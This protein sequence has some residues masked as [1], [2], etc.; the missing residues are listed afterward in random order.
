MD[1]D[2]TDIL[3]TYPSDGLRLFQ[4][5]IPTGLISIGTVLINAGYTVKIIDFNHYRDDFRRDLRRMN[6]KVVGIGGTTPSRMGSFLT[7]R[8]VKNIFPQIPVVYG[9]VHASFTAA[10]TLKNIETIDYIIKGEGEF[11]F[12]KL[13]DILTGKLH[14][15]I[16]SV[17]GLVWRQGSN[18]VENK[19]ER[20]NDLSLL[21]IP[22][23]TL[24]GNNYA[25]KM[26]FSGKSGDFIMTS[27]GCP[28]ACN[29][30]AASRMFPGGVRTRP[31]SS[32]MVEIDSLMSKKRIEGLKI[33]DSTF[34]ANREHVEHFCDSVK[35][36]NISW[37]CEIRADSV[38]RDLLKLMR[39]SGCYYINIGMETTNAEHL[40]KIAKGISPEQVLNVLDICRDLEIRSKVFF[41]FGHLNQSLSECKKDIE[42][43]KANKSKID[44]FGVT[45]GLRVYPGT[46]L[47]QEYTKNSNAINWSKS[48][49]CLSNLLIGEPGDIPVLFQNQ[50]G[51]IT[52]LY[53]LIV[54]LKNRLVCTEKYLFRMAI[55]NV[56][57][58]VK[59]ITLN[60]H[61][62]RHRIERI[63]RPV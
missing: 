57:S 20:I 2:Q 40:K 10:N 61:Y 27:R 52:L 59:M 23:R 8:I 62:T 30:C 22:D 51:P 21:P 54:L 12:Q 55:E 63:I 44:F 34:T 46:R 3:L 11:S 28:A 53:I 17:S 31:I 36:F 60:I 9:G 14:A 4:S 15:P 29:F 16:S 26:E 41:T 47:E 32:V 58:I 39:S 19:S 37:E 13:C 48:V 42:F 33:F 24:T 25:L 38:D 6:P 56:L 5:M 43:I 7:S 49:K 35:K 45:V 50:L 18:I 1:F